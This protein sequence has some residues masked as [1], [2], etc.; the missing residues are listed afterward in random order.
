VTV[1]RILVYPHA[2]E[3]GGSQLNA[4]ELAAAVRA[5]GH[6]VSVLSEEGP[7]LKRVGELGLPHLPLPE[8]RRRPSPVVARHIRELVARS[9]VD[10]VHGYEWPPGIEAATACLGTP[11]AAVCTVMSMAV[12]PF[13]PRRLPLVVGTEA[14]RQSTGASRPGPVDLIEPPVD[15]AANAPGVPTGAF[16]ARFGLDDRTLPGTG[17]PIV[18]VA[19]V[20]RLVP[21]LKLEGILT[22]IDAIG[23]LA[24]AGRP[25]RLVVVG[26]GTA[27]ATVEEHAERANARAG[28][29]AVVLTGELT[30]PRPAYAAADVLL[31]MGGSALRALAFE[32]PLVVQGERAFWELLTPESVDTFLHQGWYGIGN[33][34]DA[35]ERLTA[36][37]LPLVDDAALR[38]SLG[39]FGRQLAVDRFSL[40]AA[41]RTQEQIYR[42][43]L[44]ARR[45]TPRDTADLGRSLAGL[46]VHKARERV[47]RVRGNAAR[48]D[49]NAT[50]RAAAALRPRETSAGRPS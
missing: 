12:A 22:A 2:M 9:D 43:A 1:L 34:A 27:R 50:E 11:A 13:L 8:R 5:L 48:D 24:A 25:V 26:D 14:I 38:S 45:D 37:L 17:E 23:S 31:G 36:I 18:D 44:A 46:V 10:V 30:D 29:R 39:R 21:E 42:R 49:F 47:R 40:Q 4:V 32:R 19:V 15:V 41:A 20:T 35:V 28:R 6:H 33:G 3:I 16:R 7:L